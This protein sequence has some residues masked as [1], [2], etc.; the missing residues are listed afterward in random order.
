MFI[1]TKIIRE[2]LFHFFIIGG[3]IFLL[4]NLWGNRDYIPSDNEINVTANRI[5][6][7]VNQW[8]VQMGRSATQ[9]EIRGFIEE[10]I[11]DEVLNREAKLLGLDKNDIVVR[12]RLAQKMA[13]MSSEFILIDPADDEQLLSYFYSNINKYIQPATVSFF[14]VYINSRE[15]SDNEIDSKAKSI[16]AR[17]ILEKVATDNLSNYGDM[18]LLSDFYSA[19]TADEINKVFGVPDFTDEII[20]IPG[21]TWDGPF[22]SGYGHHLIFIVDKKDSITPSFSKV[23]EQVEKDF[24]DIRQKEAEDQFYKKL[25][26]RYII[27]IEKELLPLYNV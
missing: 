23:K 7:R 20:N 27:N 14:Q 6:T 15:L 3:L 5:E 9:D 21:Q 24:M 19:M 4:N 10:Y 16:K 17:L 8:S 18:S 25:K 13:F 22:E 1:L 12:R 26:S 11:R 2:P